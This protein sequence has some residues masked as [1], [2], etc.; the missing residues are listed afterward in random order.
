MQTRNMML[1][2]GFVTLWI[3]ISPTS[4][5]ADPPRIV[6][7]GDSLTAGYGLDPDVAYP[8]L[9][10]KMLAETGLPVEIVNAGVSGDTT[11]GGLRRINWLSRRPMDILMIA[12]GANDALRGFDTAT[13]RSNLEEIVR[14]ARSHQP[15]VRIVLAGMLAPPNM[16]GEYQRDFAAVYHELATE[17]GLNLIPFLLEGVAGERHLNLGDGIHP[18]TAGHQII[19]R[20]VFSKLK[21]VL[22]AFN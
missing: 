11:A 7:L 16:G 15:E 14:Q 10:G 2:L 8:A 3:G 5:A 9:V 6:F 20:L 18:N 19:A 12:L 22:E 17:H 13:T 21:P 1:L 4:L